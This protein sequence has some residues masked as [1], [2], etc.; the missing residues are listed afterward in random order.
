MVAGGVD[1][2]MDSFA[3]VEI[4]SESE[5]S[6]RFAADLPGPRSCM[7]G[8]TVVNQLFMTGILSTL[9]THKRVIKGDPE[10]MYK[11][12]NKTILN[13]DCLTA[14]HCPDRSLL[15]SRKISKWA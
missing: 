8:V 15:K 3:S 9:S 10:K 2:M 13:F 4:K 7:R 14:L 12:T 11:V 6:W 1:V 5:K